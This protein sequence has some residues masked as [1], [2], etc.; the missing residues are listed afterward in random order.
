MGFL[1]RY[2]PAEWRVFG[3][4]HERYR[5]RIVL[6]NV[7]EN[8]LPGKLLYPGSGYGG[9]L[10]FGLFSDFSVYGFDIEWEKCVRTANA[11][12]T[13]QADAAAMPYADSSFDIVLLDLVLHHL[14]VPHNILE[15]AVQESVRVLRPG[16]WFLA[17]EP[18]LWN[19]IGLSIET[20]RKLGVV[21]RIRGRNDDI[22]LSPRH[23]QEILVAN[24][25]TMETKGVTFTWRRLP[26]FVQKII[27]AVEPYLIN[28]RLGQ[29]AR[30]VTFVGQKAPDRATVPS[31]SRE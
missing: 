13:V 21:T 8:I 11:M 19:P 22:P 17:F 29:F 31:Q 24:G 16:G 3:E 23:I 26:L 5:E 28:T 18:N 2:I 30:T 12:P 27:I 6:R 10:N 1:N 14:I 7:T 20:A 4:K 25:C 9:I 15:D